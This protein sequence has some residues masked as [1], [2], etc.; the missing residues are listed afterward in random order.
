MKTLGLA[1]ALAVAMPSFAAPP[2]PLNTT[3]VD[4][5]VAKPAKGTRIIALWALDCAYCEQNLKALADWQRKHA[6][7]DLVFVATD[8]MSQSVTLE[9]RLKAAHVDTVPSRAYA[10]STPDRINF[11]ID[12][13]WGGETP[14][15]MVIKSDGT[16]RAL[17]GALTT[18]RISKLLD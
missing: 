14:R 2:V 10:E 11:L 5:L 3:D 8:P 17:S 1:L 13:A 12:P 15:T 9:A 7:V 16:R 18:A 4:A 6:D